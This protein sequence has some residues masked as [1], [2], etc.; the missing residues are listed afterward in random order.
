MKKIVLAILIALS[1]II[2]QES[3]EKQNPFFNVK[4]SNGGSFLLDSLPHF[5][6]MY[7]K[8]GGMQK[9]NLT[10]K[11]EIVIEKQFAKMVKVIMPSREKI[12]KIENEI[13]LKVVHHGA[14]EK[15]LEAQLL[16]VAN[17]KMK[18][19][20]IQIECLNIFRDTLTKEQYQVMIDMAIKHSKER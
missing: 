17:L 3:S 19:T 18:L 10:D 12:K 1:P 2:A 7:M 20:N 14:K 16:D 9:I 5:M 11:Q 13:V 15:E 6:G 8:H 4:E